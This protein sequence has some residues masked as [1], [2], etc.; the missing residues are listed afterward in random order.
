MGHRQHRRRPAFTL[1]EL[2][3]VLAI[4]LIL[5]ALLLPAVQR[6]REASNRVECGNNLKQIGIALTNYHDTRGSLPSGYITDQLIVDPGGTSP[7]WG[8]ASLILPFIEQDNLYAQLHFD[9]PIEN[10]INSPAIAIVLK[11]YVC[12]SDRWT[13][14]FTVRD[15]A[16]QPVV[17]AATNSYAAAFGTTEVEGGIS[18][19]GILVT[20]DSGDGVFFRNSQVR[21]R[22]VTDGTAYTLAIGERGALVSQ[23][24]WAGAIETGECWISPKAPTTATSPEDPATMALANSRLTINDPN[25]NSDQWMTPHP[26][27]AIFLFVDGSVRPLRQGIDLPV[28]QALTT[29]AGSEPN[30]MDEF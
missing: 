8:W 25:A 5:I 4:I 18:P 30:P 28:L 10:P 23:V 19:G 15:A 1:I 29:R 14:K 13:G 21:F 27:S 6:V 3:V 11:I 24:P 7:G 12:P 2:L 9:T 17:D 16:G 26:E 22:D 20:A